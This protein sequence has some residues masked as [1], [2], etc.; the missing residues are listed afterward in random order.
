MVV[1]VYVPRRFYRSTAVSHC[2]VR[3]NANTS[4]DMG[5]HGTE[6]RLWQCL[7]FVDVFIRDYED[8]R[9]VPAD[10]EYATL[11]L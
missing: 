5:L 10:L 1:V 4:L 7:K 9:I 6:L 8:V 11:E 2:P 3:M